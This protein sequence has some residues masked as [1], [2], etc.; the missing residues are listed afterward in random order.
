[1]L[2]GNE[3]FVMIDDQK[4]VFETALQLAR[5][6]RVTGEK[7]VFIVRGGPGTGKSVIGG[8]SESVGLEEQCAAERLLE[9]A[10]CR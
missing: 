10:P 4:V 6:A 8:H 9:E 3:E 1:M 2:R 5:E 7:C